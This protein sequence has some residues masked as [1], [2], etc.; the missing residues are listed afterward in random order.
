M[1]LLNYV[2]IETENQETRPAGEGWEFWSMRI[3]QDENVAVW[4]RDADIYGE[5]EEVQQ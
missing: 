3:T 5:A 4:R 2:Y 1:D